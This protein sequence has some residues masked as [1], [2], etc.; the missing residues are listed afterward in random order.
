MLLCPSA[1][2][3]INVNERLTPRTPLLIKD[4]P[5]ASLTKTSCVHTYIH[6]SDVVAALELD[7]MISSR[8][9]AVPECSGLCGA[10]VERETEEKKRERERRE[11]EREREREIIRND[12]P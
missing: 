8:A 5:L 9:L 11:E 12:T 10:D 7:G 6:I 4:R 3:L 2:G 1:P